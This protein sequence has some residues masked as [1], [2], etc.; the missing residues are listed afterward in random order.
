M[1]SLISAQLQ[2]LTFGAIFVEALFTNHFGMFPKKIIWNVQLMT[3]QFIHACIVHVYN[4]QQSMCPCTVNN[5]I[6]DN[7][8]HKYFDEYTSVCELVDLQTTG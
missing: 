4:I 7:D 5:Y 3:L 6:T 8:C 2:M 1:L